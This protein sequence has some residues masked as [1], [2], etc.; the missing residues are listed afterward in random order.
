[1]KHE[2]VAFYDAVDLKPMSLV[3]SQLFGESK[4]IRFYNAALYRTETR[5]A[6]TV[7]S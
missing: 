1:M 7:W 4:N 3:V 6:K 2:S 5:C